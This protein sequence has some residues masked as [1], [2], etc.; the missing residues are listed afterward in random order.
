VE[1]TLDPT[2]LINSVGSGKR[3]KLL[4]LIVCSFRGIVVVRHF[5]FCSA[6]HKLWCFL[7]V[8]TVACIR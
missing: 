5:Y 3:G 7:I 6:E 4:A 8:Y 1:I 2:S